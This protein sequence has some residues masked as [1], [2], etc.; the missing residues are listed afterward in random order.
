MSR[1]LKHFYKDKLR[2]LGC[3]A[4]RGKGSRETLEPFS[5]DYKKIGDKH[6]AG[7]I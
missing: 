2:E 1:G 7:H 6:L 5:G 3:S 4:Q